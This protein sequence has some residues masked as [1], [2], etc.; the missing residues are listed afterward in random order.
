MMV[1]GTLLIDFRGARAEVIYR[2]TDDDV[3]WWFSHERLN[4]IPLSAQEWRDIRHEI[5]GGGNGLVG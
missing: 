4:D 1:V 2:R 5:L 3:T